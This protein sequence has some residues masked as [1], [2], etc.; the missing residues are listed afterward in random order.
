MRRKSKEA[1]KD[2]PQCRGGY[3]FGCRHEP[4]DFGKVKNVLCYKCSTRLGCSFCVERV[5][6]LIC[7]RCHDWAS[8]EALDKH[9]RMVPREKGAEM[10]KIVMMIHAGKVTV[11]DGQKLFDE[12]MN[13]AE[14]G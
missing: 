6:E 12:L 9:G 13:L 11:D 14:G 4:H 5:T 10:M 7:N 8:K 1:E 3:S 2:K